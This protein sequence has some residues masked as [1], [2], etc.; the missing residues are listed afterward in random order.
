MN[1]AATDSWAA[2]KKHDTAEF[3]FRSVRKSTHANWFL[4]GVMFNV[5]GPVQYS[6]YSGPVGFGA[7]ICEQ[8]LMKLKES[9]VP[10]LKIC[11]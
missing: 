7:K 8:I 11:Q 6:F 2:R 3:A 5:I 9:L 10:S 4:N 1:F